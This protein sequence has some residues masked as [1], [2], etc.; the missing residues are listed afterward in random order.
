MSL[1]IQLMAR[2]GKNS[3][4]DEKMQK[5]LGTLE[6]LA[7]DGFNPF[8]NMNNSYS[9]WPIFVVSYNMP[10]WVCMEESNFMMALLISR[11]SS[12]RDFDIF[13]EPLIEELQQLWK[14]VWATD[15][16]MGK[17]FKLRVVVLWCIHDYPALS[18]LYGQVAKGYFAC[19]CC[20][21]DP[22]SRRLKN[23]ICYLGH[24]RFLPTNH[25][26]RRKR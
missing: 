1:A 10:S 13:M 17:G 26:W 16:L 6:G 9:M 24:C 7:T 14:R 4:K 2:H 8:G 18:M 23:K 20:D 15:T 5:M 25:T 11:P 22:C 19:M 3:I 12:P 21:M